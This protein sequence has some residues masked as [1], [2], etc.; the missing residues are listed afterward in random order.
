MFL[1]INFLISSDFVN[2]GYDEQHSVQWEQEE[3]LDIKFLVRGDVL[4]D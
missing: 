2:E 4:D 3:N 1:V